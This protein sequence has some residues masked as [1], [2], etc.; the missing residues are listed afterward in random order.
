LHN[1]APAAAAA[2]ARRVEPAWQWLGRRAP[3]LLGY[4]VVGIGR[5]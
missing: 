3:G 5:R 1:H 4:Q 2:L